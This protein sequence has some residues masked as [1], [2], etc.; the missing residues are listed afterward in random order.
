MR[1]GGEGLETGLPLASVSEEEEEEEEGIVSYPAWDAAPARHTR[2]LVLSGRGGRAGAAA[3]AAGLEDSA[4]AAASPFSAAA[5]AV[6]AAATATARARA[7]RS[8][9]SR[10]PGSTPTSKCSA[11]GHGRSS[12]ASESLGPA[13]VSG[14]AGAGDAGVKDGG[15]AVAAST[16]ASASAAAASAA[17]PLEDEVSRPAG[18]TLEV[19]L[20]IE[21]VSVPLLHPLLLPNL[22]ESTAARKRAE[23]SLR[24]LLAGCLRIGE[25]GGKKERC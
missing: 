23:L 25:R 14:G 7:A 17:A 15:T 21:F 3:A 5:A 22:S 1:V 12:L 9:S 8:S 24:A 19:S 13:E 20:I 18:E 16:T 6:A 11:G 4:V 10:S 2:A